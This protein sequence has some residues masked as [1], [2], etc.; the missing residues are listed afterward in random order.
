MARRGSGSK[1]KQR[2]ALSIFTALAI[3]VLIGFVGL[4]IDTARVYTIHDELQ[5]AVDSCALA[6][7]LELN[8]GTDA[9][10]RAT[11]IGRF[12]AAKNSANLQSAAVAI[13]ESGV[14]FSSTLRGNFV[15]ATSISGA[16]ASYV[17]CRAQLTGISAY[18]MSVL[19]VGDVDLA[20]SATA[21]AAPAQTV[22]SL[23][24]ALCAG[25]K[26]GTGNVFGYKA[27][28]KAVLGA[29]SSS[30][31]FTWADVINTTPVPGLKPYADALA[32]GG[33]CGVRTSTGRCIG[34]QTGVVASLD[35]AW[36]AR[37][38]A[39][40]SNGLNPTDAVPDLT[41]YGY[42]D[43]NNPAK[44]WIEDYLSVRVPART[45]NQLNLPGYTVI[46]DVNRTH[47][48]PYRRLSIMPVV[49]CGSNACGKSSKPIS[50]WA[51]VLMLAVK[52]SSENAEIEIVA[53]ADDPASPCR[54]SGVAGGSGAMGPLVPVIVQ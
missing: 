33:T 46:P 31:F 37:F 45:A 15:P 5:S 36:N 42:R 52:T 16:N 17:R 12:V 49:E 9:A 43:G 3:F 21:A 14:T 32:G 2:G 25:N 13:P 30:G 40:K 24:M 47:G 28:E 6:G 34:I 10:T 23:P 29:T 50:G 27:G 1:S 38:G 11:A 39:Y 53:R 35:D 8:G 54:A 22:C 41:G 20:A 19:G 48:A 7:A 26:G 4:A 44:G 51:C 18:L